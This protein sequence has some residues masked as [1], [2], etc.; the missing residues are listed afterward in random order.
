MYRYFAGSYDTREEAEKV[1]QE[2]IGKG[3]PYASVIDLEEQR[4][5][6][7][8]NCPY[9]RNGGPVYV[10]DPRREATL[11]NIYFDFGRSSLNANR[12][13][14]QYGWRKTQAK[15]QP[16]I[17]T[18]RLYGWCRQRPSQHATRRQPHRSARNYL[19][20]KG[21][22]ADRMFIKVY[23]EADPEMDNAEEVGEGTS[24]RFA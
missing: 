4:V 18:A 9:F 3:F 5:L 16:E 24:G 2:M 8:A 15:S 1:Q 11:Q 17:K 12:R 22:R 7:G 19:I 14:A 10:K 20:N 23:G 13:S 21:I 6:C